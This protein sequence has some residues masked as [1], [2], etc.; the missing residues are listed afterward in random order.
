MLTLTS[1]RCS[2]VMALAHDEKTR[3]T[4][5]ISSIIIGISIFIFLYL[6]VLFNFIFTKRFGH[7]RPLYPVAAGFSSQNSFYGTTNIT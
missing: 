7:H 4:R 2:V 6:I 5:P 3:L 1:R